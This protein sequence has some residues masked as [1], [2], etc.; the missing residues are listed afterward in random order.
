MRRR[1]GVSGEFGERIAADAVAVTR[2]TREHDDV[3]QG[4]SV[5]GAIDTAMIVVQLAAG[6]DIISAEDDGYADMFYDAMIV[7]SALLSGCTV[8]YTEDM[9]RGQVIDGK[10]TL[11]N[12]FLSR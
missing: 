9:Q 1:A 4:S 7:A 12:P 11:H 10:L 2:A 5:R 3:R 6:R 8:L